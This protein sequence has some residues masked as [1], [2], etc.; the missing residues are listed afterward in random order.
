[1]ARGI[2]EPSSGSIKA[3][4]Y[5]CDRCHGQKLRCPRSQA[6]DKPCLRCQ[7][8][9]VPCTLSVAH[10]VGRPPNSRNRISSLLPTSLH[11]QNTRPGR[12][13]RDMRRSPD[14]S[15]KEHCKLHKP[16]QDL[17]PSEN[18]SMMDLD[19]SS[20]VPHSTAPTQAS[21]SVTSDSAV[22]MDTTTPITRSI[23]SICD[24]ESEENNTSVDSG[25]YMAIWSAQ[26]IVIRSDL[27]ENYDCPNLDSPDEPTPEVNEI[28]VS[29]HPDSHGIYRNEPM[30]DYTASS[31][32][33]HSQES[34]ISQSRQTKPICQT[35]AEEEFQGS[36]HHWG[37][38]S[39]QAGASIPS[40]EWLSH[41]KFVTCLPKLVD[42]N[43]NLLRL[44]EKSRVTTAQSLKAPAGR[45]NEVII[46][47]VQYSRELI[48]L[49]TYIKP[50]CRSSRDS[51][52]RQS[53]TDISYSIYDTSTHSGS[54]S[55]SLDPD[56]YVQ[57]DILSDVASGGRTE[58]GSRRDSMS[59]STLIFLV[60]GCYTQI[61]YVFETII[62][63]LY[64]DPTASASQSRSGSSLETCLHIHT[65][66]YLLDH[67][68]KALSAYPPDIPRDNEFDNIIYND[69]SN[70]RA[71]GLRC[72]TPAFGKSTAGILLGQAS[73][74]IGEREKGL[75]SKIQTLSHTVNISRYYN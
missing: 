16:P 7:K 49:M 20:I 18:G 58:A 66:T 9:Q 26:V 14:G 19:P 72:A 38:F 22:S 39:A 21:F 53:S 17:N 64:Q 69:D 23:P 25:Q 65:I 56:M 75:A 50:T 6:A 27:A 10:K 55:H 42:L 13:F 43:M 57:Y 15:T 48:D 60:M 59:A 74:E 34:T 62:D 68:H 35:F 1:M 36:F 32:S 40:Y 12:S 44:S 71:Q 3:L 8:A 61:M 45:E 41:S 73:W 47:I 46:E 24:Q 70:L 51:L 30:L 29:H 31:G 33:S 11:A 63:C 37:G 52:A 54:S 4:R 5:A 67:L 28:G 2:P